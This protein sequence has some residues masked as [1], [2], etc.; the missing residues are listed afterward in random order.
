[1][2]HV[3]LP[4]N[5]SLQASTNAFNNYVGSQKGKEARRL[6]RI[7]IKVRQCFMI[8]EQ[9][10]GKPE[11]LARARPK[12]FR[13]GQRAG[14]ALYK[15]YDS[16]SAAVKQIKETIKEATDWWCPY[17]GFRIRDMGESMSPDRDHIIPR[18]E[19]PEFAIFL[20]NLIL[21][22]HECNTIKGSKCTSASEW[23]MI[24]PY[25]DVFLSN[26]LLQAQVRRSERALVLDYSLDT[27]GLSRKEK[28]RLRLFF[29]E[30]QLARRLRLDVLDHFS[31]QINDLVTSQ[32][33]GF[34]L[35]ARK[36]I[37]RT[38]AAKTLALRPNDP[39]A[40]ADLALV[41]YSGLAK[42]IKGLSP[43]A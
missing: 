21:A 3:S 42:F 38:T 27:S 18:S 28:I 41:R 23:I 36:K 22:C 29:K 10:G 5:F 43:G 17:C 20:Q 25:Y 15:A 35:R 6:A 24:N 39:F 37:I 32:M 13:Q 33:E 1:M 34:S 31:R 14:N 4:S 12:S 2:R 7:S 8:Y 30:M 40:L 16:T 26:P 19:F 11:A 9:S